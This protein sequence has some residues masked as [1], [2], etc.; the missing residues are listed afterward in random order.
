LFPFGFGLSYTRFAYQDLEI[1][2]GKDLR[3]TFSVTN[4]GTRAGSDVPQAY[5]VSANGERALR[6]IGFRR[7]TL[8]PG[9][10]TRIDLSVDRR[11]LGHFDE[12]SHRWRISAGAYEVAVAPS[13]VERTL[14]G[15]ARL[16]A[17]VLPP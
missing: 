9:Q 13:A 2:A 15:T 8:A 4:V 1:H 14:T 3:L 7:V 17:S 6:L 10:S 5:L 16:A 12:H 11:L